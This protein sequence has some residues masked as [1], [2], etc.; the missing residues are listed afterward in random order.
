MKKKFFIIVFL[1]ACWTSYADL[2]SGS[3]PS[4]PKTVTSAPAVERAAVP[5]QRVLVKPGDTLLSITERI[6][7]TEPPIERMIKDFTVLNPSVDPNHLQIG[8][9]YAFPVYD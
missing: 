1:I 5:F 7:K 9:T 4:E 8:K 6:N 3:L 2:T